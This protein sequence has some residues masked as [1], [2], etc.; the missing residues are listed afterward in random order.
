MTGKECSASFYPFI[1]KAH[2]YYP[3]KI[4]Q[5]LRDENVGLL[6][7]FKTGFTVYVI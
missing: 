6:D 3:H 1:L 7:L 2:W 5:K 4:Y